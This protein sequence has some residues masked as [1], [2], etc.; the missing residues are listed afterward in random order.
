MPSSRLPLSFGALPFLS[1]SRKNLTVPS[2][3]GSV[4]LPT[5]SLSEN[6]VEPGDDTVAALS[7]AKGHRKAVPDSRNFLK[8]LIA[9]SHNPTYPS[10]T[11]SLP[12]SSRSIS[13]HF[14][15]VSDVQYARL[16]TARG[17]KVLMHDGK[18]VAVRRRRS[19]REAV[20]KLEEAMR[21][22]DKARVD[23]TVNLGDAIEGYGRK[24]ERRSGE[25]LRKVCGVFAA[26]ASKVYHVVGNH[27][28][29]V[30]LP[31]LQQ[32]LG[33]K[34]LYY[35]FCPADGWRCVVLHSAELCGGTADA[36]EEEG[37]ML[38]SIVEREGRTMHHFH[39][40][41]GEEQLKWLETQLDQAEDEGER[42]VLLS[43]HPLADNSARASHVVANTKQVRGIVERKRTP[44]VL[45]LAGHD[46]MGESFCIFIVQCVFKTPRE[47]TNCFDLGSS[48][49]ALLQGG[50]GRCP[51]LN[52][53]GL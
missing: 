8:Y 24:E 38:R 15:V 35:A 44:V 27:C 14:G 34:E 43:H 20:G 21:A 6:S 42:V 26:A 9:L 22:F 45:C 28:R 12:P 2:D 52:S 19:W 7:S 18:L 30:P 23:F 5:M 11:T 51:P 40:A 49:L 25:D 1:P 32:A 47:R 10:P 4:C 53:G 29:R 16:P 50:S 31:Q 41:L 39:G 46:H 36:T 48:L 17:V 3:V 37:E 33:L 13:F